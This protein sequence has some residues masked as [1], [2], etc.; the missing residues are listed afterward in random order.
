[1]KIMKSIYDLYKKLRTIVGADGKEK[2]SIN[3]I[4]NFPYCAV[5]H[6]QV[7]GDT[8]SV[9]LTTDNNG[10]ITELGYN[11][12]G[13]L[14][15]EASMR[16]LSNCITGKTVQEASAIINQFYNSLAQKQE[17]PASNEQVV[18]SL[19]VFL[20]LIEYPG[21]IGCALLPAEALNDIFSANIP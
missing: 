4:N 18:E 20:E 13:C 12:D 19:Q 1:M 9:G 11:V 7:C 14:V 6:N 2:M 15:C 5:R 3:D 10:V 21:R 16:A 8:V 17:P